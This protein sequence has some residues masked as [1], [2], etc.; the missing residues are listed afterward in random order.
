MIA[1]A[2]RVSTKFEGWKVFVFD[3]DGKAGQLE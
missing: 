3:E 1:G 2:F